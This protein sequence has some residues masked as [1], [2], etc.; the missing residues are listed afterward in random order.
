MARTL[1]PRKVTLLALWDEQPIGDGPGGTAHMV[2][3]ARGQADVNIEII[4]TTS[5]HP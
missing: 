1:G 4:R 2:S 3:L 5:L